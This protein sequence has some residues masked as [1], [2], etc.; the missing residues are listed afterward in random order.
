MSFSHISRGRSDGYGVE[1]LYELPR[2]EGG[3]DIQGA[4][5]S[6]ENLPTERPEGLAPRTNSPSFGQAQ[7]APHPATSAATP[8]PEQI[9][10]EMG[11]RPGGNREAQQVAVEFLGR[12]EVVA[13]YREVVHALNAH[14]A[15]LPC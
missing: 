3:S 5:D 10:G 12:F 13:Q 1:F 6:L 2:D 7:P 9:G 15:F 8:R 11:I 4:N 14:A